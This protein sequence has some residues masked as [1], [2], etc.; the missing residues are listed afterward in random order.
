[1]NLEENKRKPGQ[2]D[3]LQL[4]CAPIPIVRI[5]FVGLGKKGKETFNN[6]MYMDGIEVVA[7]CDKVEEN[8]Q[9]TKKVLAAHQK[10]EAATYTKPDDWRLICE[11]SDIDLIYVCTDRN[12][13]TPIAVYAMQC[14]KHV[15][16]EVPAA[17]SLSECW[18]LVNT[19]EQTRRHCIMLENC[20][21][22]YNSLTFLNMVQQGLFGEVFHAEGGY[23]HD[24]KNLDFKNKPHYQDLWSMHGNPYPTHGLGPLC[25][26]L[27]IHRGD[28]LVGLTS[29]SSGQF[30]FPPTFDAVKPGNCILGNIN[31]T[32]LKTL[33]NKTIVLQHD[34]SS[35]RPYSRNYMFSGTKGFVQNR[36]DPQIALASETNEFL[37]AE[38]VEKLMNTYEHPFYKTTSNLTHPIGSHGGMN[39][40]MDF[41]LIYCLQNGLPLDMDVYDAAE[42]SSLVELTSI[43]VENNALMVQIPDFT[44]GNWDKLEGLCFH[45]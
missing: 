16:I 15:A 7:L 31:T 39:F 26:L 14:G 32:I 4:N 19:A 42:W 33:K 18:Q 35:P 23:V 3:V 45:S 2:S 41:R 20:C 24:L 40:M 44:R 21:Y 36:K 13:H 22:D 1:M 27:N 6:F 17:N 5:A 10:K 34:V 37:S 28:K 9:I 43:S 11:R 30:N 25:Q 12:L 29:V 38:E 8:I